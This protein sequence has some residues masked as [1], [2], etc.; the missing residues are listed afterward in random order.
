[1]NK[2]ALGLMSGTSADGLTLALLDVKAKE[3]VCFKNYPYPKNLQK[4]ILQAPEFNT[5]QLAELNF[6]LGKIYLALTQKFIKDFKINKSDI[7]VIGLHGQTVYHNA[8]TSCTLQIGEAAFLAKNLG[9][10]VAN[11]FRPSA[12]ALG[13]QG[14]PLVP[15]FEDYFFAG[16]IPKILLNIG[17]ISNA[18]YVQKGKTFGFDCGP[19][20]VLNDY[21]ITK[22]SKGKNTFDKDGEIAANTKPDTNKAQKIAK[23]F[24]YKK[25]ISLDR[26]DFTETFFKKYFPQLKLKDVSTLNYLTALIIAQNVKKFILNK[27]NVKDLYVSGGGVYNKTL[28]NNLKTLLPL[29]IKILDTLNPMAK[30]AACFA[31]FAHLTLNKIPV[32]KY[33]LGTIKNTIIGVLNWP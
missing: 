28:I 23:N 32:N 10:T 21:A 12:I 16:K 3:L 13:G 18:S 5:K 17:G 31:Y 9:I 11:N 24:E 8:K 29:N 26:R 20:N 6:K 25:M 15:V 4:E 1:M 27:Y 7:S 19:G 33:L 14:A 22:L 2:F 30:E